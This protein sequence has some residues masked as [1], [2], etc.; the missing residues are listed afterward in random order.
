MKTKE[1]RQFYN[2]YFRYVYKIVANY[3]PILEDRE[4]VVSEVFIDLCEVF[5][6]IDESKNVKALVFT[7]TKRKVN[8]LLRKK[9]KLTENEVW[10]QDISE[11]GYKEED[12]VGKK[13]FL[14]ELV[15]DLN[16]K[17][18]KIYILK[19]EQNLSFSQI[20]KELNITKSYAKVLHNRLKK[21][22][23]II[24]NQK[25]QNT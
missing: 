14:D 22:I 7:I 21:Q 18:K 10:I 16:L 5:E 23:K 15:K 1:F 13:N 19:Y 6:N 8:D 3:I 12:S 11:L 4:D 20:A 9:Y 17:Y 24:W 2:Q 25:K